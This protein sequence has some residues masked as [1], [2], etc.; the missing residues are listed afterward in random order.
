MALHPNSKR[1]IGDG[2]N[3]NPVQT[4]DTKAGGYGL[5]LAANGLCSIDPDSVDLA[6]EG[7]RRCGFDL[8]TMM[9]AGVRTSSTRPGSG[10]RSTF[11]APPRGRWLKFSSKVY[12]TVLELR[13]ASP[14]VQDCLAGT[15]YS[16]QD[17]GGPYRQDYANGRR[18]DDAPELPPA[19]ANWWI[20]MSEDVEFLRVQQGLLVGPDAML[21]VSSG[22]GTLAYSSALRS[23]F[24]DAN[25][26][27]DILQRNGYTETRGRWA[28]STATGAPAVRR[29]PS[30]VDLWQSDHASDPLFGTFDAWS[31]Y[32]V[33]D[34]GGDLASAEA[35]WDIKRLNDQALG[36]ADE[37]GPLAALEL[38]AF[39]RIKSG[40]ITPTKSNLVKAMAR[41]DVCGFHVQFD[42]FRA[43]T[44]LAE[45]GSNGWRLLKDTD[46]VELC[47]HLE[48]RGFQNISKDV[49]RD[50]VAYTAEAH[51][52]DA[53]Q[54]WLNDLKWD[55]QPRIERFL[56]VYFTAED[57]PYTRAV[58]LY[59]WTALAG[60]V[61]VPGIKCD[62]A[63][64]AVGEQGARKSSA[65]AALAPAE[66]FFATM[67]LSTSDDNMAR[68]MRG[69]LVIELDELKGLSTRDAD[70]IKS[71]MT[72]RFEE[73]VP[74]YREM[75]VRYMRRS[76]F[77]GTSNRDDFLGDETGNRRWLPFRCGMCDPRGIARDRD[78][79]WAE[80]RDR[81][82]VDG[83]LFEEAERLAEAEHAAFA[84]HDEWDAAIS[85][86][87]HTPDFENRT[88]FGREFLT[89]G[90][91]L[92]HALEL[93]NAQHN[94]LHTSRVKKSLIR[95][96]YT[97]GTPRIN[98]QKQR[99]FT[100]PSLF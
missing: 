92:R 89:A 93:P 87:L 6:R 98:G 54:H 40:E 61:Q 84:E 58:A 71:L 10:G 77:I 3:L 85:K 97:Y 69:K 55:G 95:Q 96:G 12:G 1:P 75:T 20:R 72:R 34:H 33:L 49:I 37:V 21:A 14:N 5:L 90:E 65:V 7:L 76:V 31:A 45:S 66:D 18:V 46:Y 82:M 30:K 73:W 42:T 91:V 74:K 64:V 8:E 26:V 94:R 17:G 23:S 67:D 78:Q 44:M 36:F 24:N 15:V 68:L 52:F 43:E 35:A 47:L 4:V 62:M 25:I 99:G 88:P 83:I 22:D 50:V 19:V 28:P 11:K 60:R 16:T 41:H 48:R 79:L 9:D 13:A 39:A 70:F 51:S 81:F 86:W 27:T 38:P 57:T 53:A 56:A 59:L 2:W 29:I 63:P 100:P 80:A 32:V